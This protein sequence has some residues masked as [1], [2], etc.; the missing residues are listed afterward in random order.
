VGAGTLFIGNRGTAGVA[1]VE[2]A[3]AADGQTALDRFVSGDQTELVEP[4]YAACYAVGG[5]DDD[6]YVGDEATSSIL[7]FS[8]AATVDGDVAPARVLAGSNVPL[9]DPRSVMV[10]TARD[11]LYAANRGGHRIYA[12]DDASTV[13]GNVAPDREIS[14]FDW[15]TDMYVDAANDRAY[16]YGGGE[17]LILDDLSTLD[18]PDTVPDRVVAGDATLLAG[19]FIAVDVARDRLYVSVRNDQRILVFHNLD[20]MEG[21]V[22]PLHIIEGD[23]TGLNAPMNICVDPARGHLYQINDTGRDQ[24]VRVWEDAPNA[25]GNVPPDRTIFSAAGMIDRVVSVFF[26]ND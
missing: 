17:L 24:T 3:T 8:P 11:I 9:E 2:G 10:D 21:N 5:A 18:G 25:D 13:D 22:A 20:T 26:L 6:L 7:V 1:A 19:S 14:Y 15:I 4:T 23:Q 16:V 12:W